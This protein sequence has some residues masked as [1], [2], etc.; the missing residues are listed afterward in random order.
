MGRE[1]TFMECDW[2]KCTAYLIRNSEPCLR[3]RPR[4]DFLF[5]LVAHVLP[6][7]CGPNNRGHARRITGTLHKAQPGESP[8]S[9]S[10]PTQQAP[11]HYVR[12]NAESVESSDFPIEYLRFRHFGLKLY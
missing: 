5:H 7:V 10:I 8:A 11:L 9:L 12:V 3:P 1:K 6:L 4:R 2:W